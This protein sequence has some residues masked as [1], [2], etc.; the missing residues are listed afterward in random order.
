MRIN[1]IIL[2]LAASILTATAQRK[3]TL[4]LDRT[5]ALATDSSLSVEK[6][7]SVLDTWRF[8]FLSWKASLKPQLSLESTPLDYEQYMVQRYISDEDRDI[9]R[10]QQM[11]YAEAAV[12]LTQ[13]IE[14]LGGTL[15][16]STG[17]GLLHTF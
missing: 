1:F 4:D 9:Y 13:D 16:A 8:A 17:L 15:Y 6:Y 12:A 7:R 11:V 10:E 2:A 14:A 3:V 5:V